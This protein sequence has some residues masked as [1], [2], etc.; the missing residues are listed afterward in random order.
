MRCAGEAPDD[1]VWTLGV[2]DGLEPFLVYQ[3]ETLVAGAAV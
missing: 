2:E 1:L 3:G